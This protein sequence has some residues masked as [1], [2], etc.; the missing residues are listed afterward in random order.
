MLIKFHGTCMNGWKFATWMKLVMLFQWCLYMYTFS[1]WVGKPLRRRSCLSQ[2]NELCNIMNMARSFPCD[3]VCGSRC[4]EVSGENLAILIFNREPIWMIL[5]CLKMSYTA[6]TQELLIAS[7][8][9]II[10]GV[11]VDVL[12]WSSYFNDFN[13]T[14]LDLLWWSEADYSSRHVSGKM[15]KMFRV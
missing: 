15:Y 7:I 14:T 11:N 1:F 4:V 9:N 2:N 5:S 6:T 8:W 3:F 12:A 10:A 13:R